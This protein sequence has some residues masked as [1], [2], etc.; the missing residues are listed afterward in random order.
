M[1]PTVQFFTT[2][3]PQDDTALLVP[4]VERQFS[5]VEESLN[6]LDSVKTTLRTAPVAA[7]DEGTKGD[8]AVDSDYIYVCT[9]TNTWKRAALTSW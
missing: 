6:L 5:G 3:L 7:T 1:R 2:P 4:V 8:L 9:A